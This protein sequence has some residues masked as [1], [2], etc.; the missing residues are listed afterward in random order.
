MATHSSTLAWKILWKEEPG[1]LP[2]MESQRVRHDWVTSLTHSWDNMEKAM[3]S[4][5]STLAWKIPWRE[6]PG[7]LQS[8]GLLWVRHDWATSLSL[9]TFMHFG[10]GNAN[11]LQCSCLEN[12]RDRGAWWAAIYGVS[13]SRTRL[14][15]LSSTGRAQLS[16]WTT[17]PDPRKYFKVVLMCLSGPKY[18]CQNFICTLIPQE[19]PPSFFFFPNLDYIVQKYLLK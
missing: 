11:P 10:E 15:Q 3:A 19:K 12:P 14:K 7:G 6:E 13:Q 1:R 4:H 18:F 9:F 5:Y 16:N 17:S 8:M 2:S